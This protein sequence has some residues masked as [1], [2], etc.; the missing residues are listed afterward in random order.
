MDSQDDESMADACGGIA[1]AIDRV[2]EGIF[3]YGRHGQ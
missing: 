1:S 2:A 3:P